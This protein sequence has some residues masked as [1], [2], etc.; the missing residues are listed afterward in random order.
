MDTDR[1]LPEFWGIDALRSGPDFPDHPVVGVN[2]REAAAYAEW[3][4]KRLPTEAEWEY[5][6]RGGLAGKAYPHGD[7]LAPE[8]A[9]YAKSDH[10]GTVAVG[11]YAPNGFGL[12]D[13]IGNAAEWTAD[14][15]G[16]DYYTTGPSEN[17][18]GP[19]DGKFAVFRGGG[20]HT[21]P[22]CC[23]VHYRNALPA[24]FRDFNVGF[25]CVKNYDGSG[26]APSE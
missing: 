16:A 8:D 11:S 21:G 15:Y 23:R 10:K 14:W 6:A 19:E 26:R 24:N 25:R 9:N 5:A 17:P 1:P 20:W 2:R 22:G 7:E 18:T 12:Y 3:C 4:G 13:I